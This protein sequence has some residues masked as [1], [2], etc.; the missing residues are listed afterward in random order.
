[1]DGA[2]STGSPDRR[3][4]RIVSKWGILL[5]DLQIV[6]HFSFLVRDIIYTS[7]SYATMLVSICL[8]HVCIVVTGC[9]GSR[10]PL[11]AWI[12]GCLCYLLTI[13]HLE[14]RMGWWRDFW[15][16]R[17]GMEKLVI[18]AILLILLIFYRWTGN[19]WR[20]CLYERCWRLTFFILVISVENALYLKNGL[21]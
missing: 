11:H 4:T 3:S 13:P 9:D 17:G 10:I 7:R 18:V 2:A 1:M 14:H 20:L 8:W 5:T 12:D 21:Y 6:L 16:K 19:T 15:W